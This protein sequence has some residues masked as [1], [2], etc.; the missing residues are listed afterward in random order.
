[1]SVLMT[2]ETMIAKA[3]RRLAAV[4]PVAKVIL[5]G[6]RVRGEGRHGNDLDLLAMSMTRCERIVSSLRR[7]PAEPATLISRKARDRVNRC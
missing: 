6:S 2:E 7:E 5:F 4:V 1:M 3:S